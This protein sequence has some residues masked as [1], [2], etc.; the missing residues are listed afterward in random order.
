MNG[1]TA[2]FYLRVSTAHQNV[3]SQRVK[4]REYA[5]KEGLIVSNEFVDRAISGA[6]PDRPAFL[7]LQQW[8]QKNTHSI[9]LL[10]ELDRSARDLGIYADLRRL[11]DTN[12]V[13]LR[14]L[15]VPQTGSL[16]TDRLL[17]GMMAVI[18]EYEKSAIKN[19]MMRGKIAKLKAGIPIVSAVPHGYIYHKVDDSGKSRIEVN[20][21]EA[22]TVK[23]IYHLFV[24]ENKS[25]HA[26]AAQLTK[27]KVPAR[28]GKR[29]IR[30]VVRRILTNETYTGNYHYGRTK[31]VDPIKKKRIARDTAEWISIPFPIIIDKPTFEKA[32]EIV[33]RRN[34]LQY[35]N[36]KKYHYLL[37]GLLK[38]GVCG[39][40]Y[41]AFRASYGTRFYRCGLRDRLDENGNYIPCR[42][43]TFK[44]DPVEELVWQD[45]VQLVLNP[46][47]Y[48]K[49][50]A[51]TSKTQE[52]T[53]KELEERIDRLK[54]KLE[55]LSKREEEFLK[56]YA[57]NKF[58]YR[59][60]QIFREK[61]KQLKEE[62]S[63]ELQENE[64]NLA[65][66]KQLHNYNPALNPARLNEKGIQ[67]VKDFPIEYRLSF[68]QQYIKAVHVL[69]QKGKYILE[70]MIPLKEKIVKL[71]PSL[72]QKNSSLSS[73]FSATIT[74]TL[75]K[76]ISLPL[77]YFKVYRIYQKPRNLPIEYG[78]STLP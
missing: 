46:E 1:Q 64:E 45:V 25:I 53:M 77:H 76:P 6:D 22:Q 43:Y 18:A 2:C 8:V 28:K 54:V 73:G 3:D 36:N 13:V 5:D 16:E 72:K 7:Q 67:V 9:V 75:L 48:W 55:N 4:L 56:D 61:G 62:Y 10:A 41:T 27:E 60:A 24:N 11:C 31:S 69:P 15:N 30:A 63:K 29:W 58:S 65:N 20:E 49:R 37:S 26:I 50:W 38:C 52:K 66:Y 59:E 78:M 34:T 21:D 12:N 14:F 71:S 47:L 74:A 57:D 23:R 33:L 70:Y 44:A 35:P 39:R 51:E 40:R 42:N 68:I 19:R 32:Q 17:E